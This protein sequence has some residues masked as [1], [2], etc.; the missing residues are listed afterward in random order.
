MSTYK[1]N[2]GFSFKTQAHVNFNEP[3]S[4]PH[5]HTCSCV[6]CWRIPS[7]LWTTSPGIWTT[8]PGIWTT[9]WPRRQQWPSIPTQSPPR[10]PLSSAHLG[11]DGNINPAQILEDDF[12]RTLCGLKIVHT[13]YTLTQQCSLWARVGPAQFVDR[14]GLA[15]L[16]PIR[17]EWKMKGWNVE[18]IWHNILLSI[19]Y[20]FNH[21]HYISSLQSSAFEKENEIHI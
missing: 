21:L 17:T 20:C 7:G 10:S 15:L 13:Q 6:I 14:E 16:N 3:L 9:G 8:F 5:K 11:L 12:L 19:R 18:E 1:M 4:I 2:L